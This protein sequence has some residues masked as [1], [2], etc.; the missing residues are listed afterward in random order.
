MTSDPDPPPSD[1][2][3]SSWS[4]SEKKR[5]KRKDEKSVVSIEKMTRQTRPRVMILMTL[6]HRMTVIIDVDDAEARN[7]GKRN[8]FVYA[9]L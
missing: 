4:D 1:L 3:D 2:S 7:T 9:Q 8:Q 6:T 5:K